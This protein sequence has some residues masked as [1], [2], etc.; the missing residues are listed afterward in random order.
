MPDWITRVRLENIRGFREL[1]FEVPMPEATAPC[2]VIIGKNGTGKSTLLRA[3]ALPLVRGEE[4]FELVRQPN[5]SYL[6]AESDAGAAI[7]VVELQLGAGARM[8]ASFRRD[9]DGEIPG[10]FAESHRANDD[11]TRRR[12][13]ER[14]FVA[15]Y[16]SGRTQ[17]G[18]MR[19]TSFGSY[20]VYDSVRALFD[21]TTALA[22]SELTL[23]RLRDY[24]DEA[25]YDATLRK[26]SA[27]IGLTPDDTISLPRGGGVAVSGPTIGADIPLEAWADGYRLTLAWI[28]DMYAWAMR[29]EAIDDEGDINGILLLDEVEQH[30]H[31]SMQLQAIPRL[32][33]QFPKLQIFATTHSPLVALSVKPEE[34]VSLKRL[35]DGSVVRV[36]VPNY[37]G[38]SAEDML[39]DDNLFD[40]DVYSPETVEKLRRYR[41]LAAKPPPPRRRRG[42]PAASAASAAA[43][44]ESELKQLGAELRAMAIPEVQAGP[45][46]DAV[47]EL[48]TRY[49]RQPEP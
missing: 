48:L 35:D 13:W 42:G 8:W 30:L 34:L 47:R 10:S 17:V 7:G 5:G 6:R 28:M 21:Y 44:D 26:L 18:T 1:E 33:A 15:A 22:N 20:R 36:E 2:T 14:L 41:E 3:I 27:A 9:P 29:A 32:R 4:A 49:G 31:P 16:G 46:A 19:E 43:A 38:Y 45:Q 12:F 24:R 23:R 40:A 25:W 11:V 39:V 37:T